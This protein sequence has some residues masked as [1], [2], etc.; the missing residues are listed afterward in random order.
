V[1]TLPSKRNSGIALIIVLIVIVVLG[2]LAGGFA[3][4]MKV[5]TTLARHAMF[6]SDLDWAGRAGVEV[7]KW[8]LAQSTTGPNGQFDSLKQKWA[9]G[10]GETNDI[11]A[12]IDLKNYPLLAPD[13]SID[14]T[15][16]IDIKDL[17]RKFNI[18]RADEVIL[19]QALT[20]VVGVD[21]SQASSIRAS[22]LNWCDPR[23]R[24]LMGG[25][26]SEYYEE[27]PDFPYYAKQGPIDDLSELMLVRGV[28]PAM[29][30]GSGGGGLPAVLNRPNRAQKSMF[31]E[32]TYA[33]GLV[34]L[35]TP[36]SSKLVN[37][38]TASATVLQMFPFIDERWAQ[39]I[40]SGPGGRAGPN[41]A[42][43][44]S[45]D[46]PFRS[47]AEL[48][49][50]GLPAEV[51]QQMTPFC[52]VRSLCFEAHINVDLRGVRREYTALLRRNGPKDIQTLN[53]YWK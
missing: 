7:S 9:G 44:D 40:I 23:G 38:N 27:L 24:N 16:S 13:G 43:G 12:E 5:E 47:V 19:D 4:T 53:L 33:V 17:D 32:P 22:I 34:D 1:K 11:L 31:D 36:V 29:Y 30:W 52:T 39:A 41:G 45:D 6:S 35:F 18:N 14:G 2:I 21:A 48:Q 46:T 51:V 8:I 28:T 26:T 15:L 3:Y 49:R 20:K 50:V 37:I 42:D 25:A 10:P